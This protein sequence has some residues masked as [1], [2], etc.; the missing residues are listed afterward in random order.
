MFATNIQDWE[1]WDSRDD[2]VEC[3]DSVAVEGTFFYDDMTFIFAWGSENGLALRR[4]GV[5]GS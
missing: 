5:H 3:R 1:R 2:F 4:A